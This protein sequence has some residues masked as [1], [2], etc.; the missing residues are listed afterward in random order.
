MALKLG[1]APAASPAAALTAAP[2]AAQTAPA[3]E[4]SAAPKAAKKTAAA[5]AAEQ[6]AAP[7]A[8]K[9]TAAAQTAPA[10]EQSAAPTAET[11][12]KKGGKKGGSESASKPKKGDM[13]GWESG[14]PK[15]TISSV[16]YSGGTKPKK[17][18]SAASGGGGGGGGGSQEKPSK[19]KKDRK[20]NKR[21]R[22]AEAGLYINPRTGLLVKADPAKSAIMK[23]RAKS[24][25]GK[26]LSAAHK[27]A[28][29]DAI[30]AVWKT[31]KTRD[32]KAAHYARKGEERKTRA[33]KAQT[34]QH[35]KELAKR[36]A[37]RQAKK[38]A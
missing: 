26:S 37:A 5:P 36:R 19:E 16:T 9:K 35:E 20:P 6:S 2:T 12:G 30:K 29:A 15:E 24:R 23:A 18:G 13:S 34:S 22:M 27:K 7:K 1:S 14:K 11:K 28:I 8:A 32:G 3:A 33:L 38:A 31:G 21:E 10:A 17:G 25:R 4:K